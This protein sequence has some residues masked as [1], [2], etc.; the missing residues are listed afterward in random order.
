MALLWIEGFDHYSTMPDLLQG[1]W[2]GADFDNGSGITLV[3]PGRYGGKA[4]QY[5]GGSTGESYMTR[6]VGAALS[7][8][9]LGYG[10]F[11]NNQP[12][13]APY[14]GVQFLSASVPQV[15]V[16]FNPNGSI[17]VN[18]NITG[19]QLAISAV[20]VYTLNVW[21]YIEIQPTINPT[22]GSIVVR[23]NGTTVL[24]A[25]GINTANGFAPAT[26][27]FDTL[28]FG[29]GSENGSFCM[30]D[31]I[32]VCDTS[33]GPGA[34]PFDSFQGECRIQTM[35][36]NGPGGSTS[37]TPLTPITSPPPGAVTGSNTQNNNILVLANNAM[38]VAVPPPQYKNPG[39][40]Y[41]Q[42]T[43][44]TGQTT[45][46]M[47]PMAPSPLLNDIQ[48]TSLTVYANGASSATLIPVIYEY[49][50]A[51]SSVGALVA[52]GTQN[53][54]IVN[55]ANTLAFSAPVALSAGAWYTMGFMIGGAAFD[56]S[57]SN[58]YTQYSAGNEEVSFY[59]VAYPTAPATLSGV[60][61]AGTMGGSAHCM[62]YA[63]NI[64]NYASVME[65]MNDGD[66]TYNYSGTVGALDLY[67]LDNPVASNSSIL[68][69][70]VTGCYRKDDSNNRSVA[71]VIQSG[72]V[73]VAGAAHVVNASYTY[74]LDVLP[75][76]P[77]TASTWTYGA[78][79]ALQIGPQVVS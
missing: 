56:F 7:S 50:S 40:G 68:A 70:Q 4:I 8:A 61:P 53:A 69:V 15:A 62:T 55:G 76:N 25:T 74:A 21:Q 24:D 57:I 18:S 65:T 44:T 49:D 11:V 67:T 29:L 45:I 39:V 46:T 19:A 79:N 3:Q 72:G 2:A 58:T 73:N 16:V 13:G 75:Q 17:S 77:A 36:P 30:I 38:F 35:F 64:A 47:P 6:T 71:Q 54:T 42:S 27:V 41:P 37:W 66:Q 20:N 48:V 26:D 51:T 34:N 31:D 10:L 60:A 1:N 22:T 43:I 14:V 5:T 52:S 32:Y 23:V 63:A 78:V 9:V 12:N 59:T 33:V 28:H